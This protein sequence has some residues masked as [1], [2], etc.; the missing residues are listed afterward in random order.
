MSMELFRNDNRLSNQ[1]IM[2]SGK[3]ALPWGKELYRYYEKASKPIA[4]KLE[5]LDLLNYRQEKSV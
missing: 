4:S 5:L 3:E 1:L 2:C